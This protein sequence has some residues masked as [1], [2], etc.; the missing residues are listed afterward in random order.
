MRLGDRMARAQL[1]LLHC[2]DRA[3]ACNRRFHLISARSDH[4]NLALRTQFS[5]AAQKVQ[6]HWP[7]S[8]RMQDLVFGGFHARTLPGG[9]DNDSEW[10]GGGHGGTRPLLLVKRSINLIALCHVWLAFATAQ[11]A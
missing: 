6:Q 1:L 7:P 5:D 4:H 8:D 2:E 3:G 11:A 9:E 10:A